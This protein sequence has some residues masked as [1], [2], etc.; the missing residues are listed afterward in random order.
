MSAISKWRASSQARLRQ[1]DAADPANRQVAGELEARW[2]KTLARVA[3]VEGKL[4]AYAAKVAPVADP[5]SLATLAADLKSAWTARAARALRVDSRRP[6]KAV[7]V[8]LDVV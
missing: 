7:A 5:V 2:N 1:Y 8:V 3:E 6:Y 4:A